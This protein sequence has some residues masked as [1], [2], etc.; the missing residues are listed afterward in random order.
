M[1]DLL[2]GVREI[3]PHEAPLDVQVNVPEHVLQRVLEAELLAHHEPLQS[4]VED[5]DQEIR[6]VETDVHDV[7]LRHTLAPSG[8]R[9]K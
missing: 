6:D 1:E 7:S 5:M 3:P 8:I 4:H 9:Q 2:L